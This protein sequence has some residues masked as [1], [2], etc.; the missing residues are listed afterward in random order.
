MITSAWG[1]P[2]SGARQQSMPSSLQSNYVK[3]PRAELPCWKAHFGMRS[4]RDIK[5][6]A[7]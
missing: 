3:D 4:E 7:L 1:S 6:F 5:S 2:I